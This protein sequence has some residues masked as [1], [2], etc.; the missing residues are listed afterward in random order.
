MS[1]NKPFALWEVQPTPEARRK[2]IA[3]E[4]GIPIKVARRNGLDRPH[5]P[6]AIRCRLNDIRRRQKKATV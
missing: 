6:L 3:M 4:H 2:R 1:K 5:T